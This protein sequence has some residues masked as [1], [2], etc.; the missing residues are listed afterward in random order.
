MT[1]ADA[2]MLDIAIW[3]DAAMLSR[4]AVF[5]RH[6]VMGMKSE[7]HRVTF[8]VTQGVDISTL[9][10]LGSRVLTYRANR[11]EQLAT[12]QRFRLSGVLAALD[13]DPPDVVVAWGCA[14]HGPLHVLAQAMPTLP[15]VV[16]CWDA[17]ELFSPLMKL[18]SLRHVIASSEAIASRVPENAQMPMTVVHPGVYC[19]ETPACFDVEGQ[20]ACLVSLDPLA[21]RPAYEA[22]IRACR[23]LADGGGGGREGGEEFLLFAYDTGKEEYAI[24]Q[25]AEELKL[26]DRLSFVPFQQDAEPL[27]LHGDLYIHVLPSTRVQYRTL[28]A[29]GRGLAVVTGPNHGADYLVDGQTCRIVD[30]QVGGGGIPT[31]EAWRDTL[32]SMM[33]ERSKTAAIARR[34][35][36]HIRERHSMGRML[37]QFSSI[38]RQAAGVSIPLQSR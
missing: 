24:W 13:E 31:A 18:R 29:M 33:N 7:G 8:I 19:E 35:Q 4:E 2:S 10:V 5:V 22:L 37:E 30:G 16:W 11:W 28:E 14:A 36:Q 20:I 23:L 6:L 32:R 26:L 34:G 38:C 3:V 1:T 15:L 9:P 21:N 27:L 12:L 25:L 17:A